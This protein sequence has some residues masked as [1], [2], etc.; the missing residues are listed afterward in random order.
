MSSEDDQKAHSVALSETI[1]PAAYSTGSPTISSAVA[2][3]PQEKGEELDD[4][5]IIAHSHEQQQLTLG[6]KKIVLVLFCMVQFFDGA[7]RSGIYPLTTPIMDDLSIKYQDSTWILNAYS[8]TFATFLPLSGLCSDLFSAKPIYTF[9]VAL[10]GLTNLAT[11]FL[12]DQYAFFV[13]RAVSGIAA[14]MTVPS[15][16]RLTSHMY[17]GDSEEDKHR[18]KMGLMM[19]GMVGGLSN[20]V[21][22]ILGG[23]FGA[24]PLSGQLAGWRWFFR[25]SAAILLPLVSSVP[26]HLSSLEKESAPMSRLSHIVR[27]LDLPAVAMLLASILLLDLSLTLASSNTTLMSSSRAYSSPEFLVPFLLSWPLLIAFFLWESRREKGMAMIPSSIW[28]T[29]NVSLIAIVALEP[30]AYWII[31]QLPYIER[32]ESVNHESTMSAA[33]RALPS[34][35][36]AFMPALILP[37]FLPRINLR[38]LLIA[39]LTGTIVALSLFTASDGRIGKWYFAFVMPAFMIGSF[40]NS[41]AVTS[42]NLLVIMSVPHQMAGTASAIVQ[43]ALQIGCAIAIAIQASFLTI[44]P[45]GLEDFRNLQISYYF[46]MGWIVLCIAMLVVMY[47]RPKPSAAV[48]SV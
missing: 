43:V 11:S 31:V 6:K 46:Q 4:I 19:L 17:Q 38:F 44:H 5:V 13:I 18:R 7:G 15:A 8:L 30:L 29:G 23:A 41:C 21:G 24:I 16:S 20:S 3:L 34:G 27:K 26:R 10:S 42:V 2:T 37:K 40:S 1:L 48:G 36:A 39:G 33:L 45:G 47:R 28:K 25:F 22:I 14:A 12:P 35:I 9:G 32:W